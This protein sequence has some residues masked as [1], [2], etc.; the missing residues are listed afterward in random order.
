LIGRSFSRRFVMIN[1]SVIA[2]CD[3]IITFLGYARLCHR[4]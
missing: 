1:S 4:M 3:F 2:L